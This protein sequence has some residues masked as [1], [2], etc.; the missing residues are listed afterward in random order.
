MVETIVWGLIWFFVGQA[1]TGFIFYVTV[2]L[3]GL[4]GAASKKAGR[5]E[6]GVGLGVVLGYLLA[7]VWEIFVITQVVIHAVTLIQL[8]VAGA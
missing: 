7:I 4:T 8:I 5:T 1:L 2:I 3:G 6:L